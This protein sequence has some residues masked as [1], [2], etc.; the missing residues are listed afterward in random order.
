[1][2]LSFVHSRLAEA[3]VLFALVAGLWG[4]VLYFRRQEM[5]ANYWGILAVGEILFAAQGIVGILLW[6]NGLRPTRGIHWLYG[7]FAVL[8]LPGY[9]L[10]SQGQDNR[11]AVLIYSLLCLFLA[12]MLQTRAKATG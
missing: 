3:A 9:Y 12:V 5:R 6:L 2:T 4:L 7:V 8:A 1:M 11:R 10:L